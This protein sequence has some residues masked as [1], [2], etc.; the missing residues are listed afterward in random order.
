V[1]FAFLVSLHAQCIVGNRV[2]LHIRPIDVS[3]WV[4]YGTLEFAGLRNEDTFSKIYEATILAQK[5]GVEIEKKE[6]T[7]GQ[8]FRANPPTDSSEDYYRVSVF[9]PFLDF[10]ASE[11]HDRFLVHRQVLT[12]FGT[13][14]TFGPDGATA[15]S[16]E[17]DFRQTVSFYGDFLEETS[18]VVSEL[19]MWKQFLRRKGV[20]P[21]NSIEAL[22]HCNENFPN[23][24]KLLQILSVGL[25][26]STSTPERTNSC[27]KRI[28]TYLRNTTEEVKRNL[29]FSQL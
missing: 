28:K 14:L 15:E 6:T 16:C 21:K 18:T 5:V 3:T 17:E 2:S 12:G 1:L 24:Q 20:Q 23:I 19:K 7:R 10:Y 22:D 29:L 4:L 27:L 25:P 8:N 9:N 26:V 13:L 11:L